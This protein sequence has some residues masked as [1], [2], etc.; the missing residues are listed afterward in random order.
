MKTIV[1]DELKSRL[2][3]AAE[4]GSVIA[5]ALLAELKSG[6]DVSEVIRGS[7][8]YFSTKRKKTTYDNYNSIKIVF[9]ACTKDITNKNFPDRLNPQA[10]WFP[11]NRTDI[12]PST[13]IGYFKNLPEYTSKDFDFFSS[14]ICLD[15]KVNIK[16]YD[17]MNDFID[18][19]K[20][21]NYS[22]IVQHG[23]T[24]LHNSCMRSEEVARNAADFYY[25]FAGAKIIVAKDSANN[26]LGRAIVWPN[27]IW[28]KEEE[29]QSISVLDRV[30]FTHTFILQKIYEYA[31]SITIH[32]RKK[33][34]DYEHSRSFIVLNPIEKFGTI[35]DMILLR[36]SSS[37]NSWM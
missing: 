8:N 18:A 3:H 13:F 6:K 25:N 19:Y 2:S 20:G 9:T 22:P 37:S 14:A 26:I 34:N 27:V 35:P 10:P 15:S 5:S 23:E 21:E 30:Y 11:E 7:A 36:P 31:Q 33:I 16:I 32:L 1:S 29:E 17:K 24:T 28:S 4:N 12:D